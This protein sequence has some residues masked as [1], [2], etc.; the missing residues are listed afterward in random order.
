M[1]VRVARTLR[2]RARSCG[3]A[4]PRGA[5][6]GSPAD[7]PPALG[8]LAKLALHLGT[9]PGVGGE[10]V[11]LVMLCGLTFNSATGTRTRVARVRAEYPNQLDYTG[12]EITMRKSCC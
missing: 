7:G 12:V 4:T 9:Q 5:Q 6:P 1:C 11:G 3:T 2:V 10:G 8:C